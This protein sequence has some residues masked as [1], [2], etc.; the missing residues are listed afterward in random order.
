MGKGGSRWRPELV[1]TLFFVADF[2]GCLAGSS[3]PRPR[4]SGGARNLASAALWRWSH[5]LRVYS[6]A[7]T[8][9]A[10]LQRG[11]VL[12][13]GVT[14]RRQQQEHRRRKAT[15]SVCVRTYVV[16]NFLEICRRE[17]ERVEK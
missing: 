1:A 12:A 2:P 15:A 5:V 16:E 3:A 9:P 4:R 13:W 14:Q 7:V 11:G 10:S 8:H 6:L 17:K